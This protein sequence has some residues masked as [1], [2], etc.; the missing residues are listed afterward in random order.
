M[1]NS[2]M[3]IF[4]H[5]L[6]FS[7]SGQVARKESIGDVLL[8]VFLKKDRLWTVA[9]CRASRRGEGAGVQ[10]AGERGVG[11]GGIGAGHAGGGVCT[12]R[13]LCRRSGCGQVGSPAGEA[14]PK[15]PIRQKALLM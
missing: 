15:S 11:G 12:A 8:F 1:N 10:G 5:Y 7:G 2:V 6:A 3:N 9:P 13:Q 14:F 4:I